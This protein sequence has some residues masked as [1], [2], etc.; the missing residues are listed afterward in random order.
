MIRMTV[1]AITPAV[2]CV[3]KRSGLI[4]IVSAQ[5]SHALTT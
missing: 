2:R 4:L 1:P 5:Y 3:Q